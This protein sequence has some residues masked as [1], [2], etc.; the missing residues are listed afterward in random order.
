MPFRR[1]NFSDNIGTYTYTTIDHIDYK[2]KKAEERP[3][4]TVHNNVLQCF[5][6]GS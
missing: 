4:V 5:A 1:A 3:Q 2:T 6:T